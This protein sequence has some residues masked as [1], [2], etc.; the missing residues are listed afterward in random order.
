MVKNAAVS[1]QRPTR[2][3][4]A[5]S[6]TELF[7]VERSGALGRH[8]A[9]QAVRRIPLD[10]MSGDNGAA[11][12]SLADA[13]REVARSHAGGGQLD[14]ALLPG[15]AEVRQLDLPPM[16]EDDLRQLLTRNSARYFV[17]ARTPQ[18]VGTIGGARRPK[19]EVG[20]VI[21]AA[22]PTR[23]VTAVVAS[24]RDA[25]WQVESVGSAAGAWA[26]AARELWPASVNGPWL[27]LVAHDDHT[28][29]L[30]LENGQLAGMRRFRT[31]GADEDAL[32]TAATASPRRISAIGLSSLRNAISAALANRGI[33]V[34]A[35]P[36]EW[37]D[38]AESPELL[39]AAF[40][41][42][43]ARP[44]LESDDV[45]AA[46]ASDV[47]R[48]V[49]LAAL[50]AVGLALLAA[51]L[52]L[53]GVRRELTAVRE[54]RAALRSQVAA[55]LVGRTSVENAF[56]QLATLGE[57]QRTA[58]HWSAVVAG[59]S[60]RLDEE[61]YLTAF[62]GRGDSVVVDGLAVRAAR[63]F[64]A[65]EHTPGLAGVHAAAPVRRE[66]PSGGPALERF[67]IAAQVAL[68]KAPAVPARAKAAP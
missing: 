46:R 8:G 56:R 36:S 52:A 3:G 16:R 24:A 20:S 43:A 11:W 27:L 63:A 68:N 1:S 64:D 32:A 21:A 14:I 28:D 38:L 33:S 15:L 50:S 7:V 35:P 12:S 37:H 10:R 19:G 25:G 17:G 44:V 34:A 65:V 31:N 53:W 60:E 48:A 23:V 49:R 58:P 41:G 54:Q 9:R 47:R 29:L 2:V 51:V 66:A 6:A 59:L 61:S 4:V 40:A 55:T 26:A 22:A 5:C 42:P 67:T 18:I 57:A 30:Q 62:R 45:R 13:L 39:A